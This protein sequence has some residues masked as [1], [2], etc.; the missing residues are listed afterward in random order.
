MQFNL[1][2]TLPTPDDGYPETEGVTELELIHALS[3]VIGWVRDNGEVDD[4]EHPVK[5]INGNRTGTWS[6]TE[7]ET[8]WVLSVYDEGADQ[9]ACPTIYCTSLAELTRAIRLWAEAT[10]AQ[11]AYIAACAGGDGL[12]VGSKTFSVERE[13]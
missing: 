10:D 5:N 4:Q 1:T 13:W 7:D 3:N 6:I 9:Q 8:P 12:T 2:I 11:V